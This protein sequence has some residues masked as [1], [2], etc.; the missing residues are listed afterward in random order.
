MIAALLVLIGTAGLAWGLGWAR[1]Y[2]GL[3]RMAAVLGT[4]LGLAVALMS[5]GLQGGGAVGVAV[6]WPPLLR[7][8]GEP[9]YWSDALSAGL[10][11]WCLLVG[12]LCLLL[13]RRERGGLP[14]G[15]AI[16]ATLYSMAY[17]LS[18]LAFAAQALLLAGLAWALIEAER[19]EDDADLTRS[20]ARGQAPLA[21]ALG[22][23]PLLGAALIVGRTTGGEYALPELSLSALTRWPL[24]LV[25][26]F[27]FL[28]LGL[29]PVTG[30]SIAA[31]SGGASAMLQ[32]LVAGVP[33]TLLLLRMQALLTAQ[34]V[35]GSV[36]GA[37]GAFMAAVAWGGGITAVAAGAG[38]ILAAGTARW[39]ALLTAHA[40]GLVAWALG[41]DTPTSRVA[42]LAM[43]AAFGAAR[44]TYEM[45]RQA[46]GEGDGANVAGG[47]AAFALA[48]A[49]LTAGFVGVWLLGAA[50]A[51][52]ERP[53]LAVLLAGAVALAACGTA[54]HAASNARSTDAAPGSLPGRGESRALLLGAVGGSVALLVG[55]TA[56]WLWLPQ[57]AAMSSVAGG[58]Q[59][60]GL[61]WVG[62]S[63][64][65]D[66]LAPLT[67]LGL[68]SV[69]IAGAGWLIVRWARSSAN[70]TGSL[71]P[72][73]FARLRDSEEPPRIEVTRFPVPTP[74]WWL[75]LV[76][77]EEGVWGLGALLVRLGTRVGIGLGRLEGRYYLPLALILA[78]VALLAVTR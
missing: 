9:L 60:V 23:M 15:V 33:V 50:L 76:W 4:A 73:A 48:A 13:V 35:A 43:L 16:L 56:P 58:A 63:A 19:G 74:V 75:S 39:L 69:A 3:A 27:A 20:T 49:P 46:R 36:P 51:Q 65:P 17:T 72:T 66:L 40:M 22:G 41:L 70:T 59:Q 12:G 44:V 28:W 31:V 32:A 25:T 38:T 10:G 18:L 71:L 24:V 78:L 42:A 52:G 34:G 11:A 55:G 6:P 2:E 77:L 68:T 30:W 61:P 8:A 64:G 47:V 26:L 14:V 57:V 54:L 67:L 21:L 53:S 7:W 62:V 29:A 5:E 1:G 45:A 37:W